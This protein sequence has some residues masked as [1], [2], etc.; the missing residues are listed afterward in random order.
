MYLNGAIVTLSVDKEH[1]DGSD[2]LSLKTGTCG[3]VVQQRH[4]D[5]TYGNHEYIVDFGPYGQWHC[6]HDELSGNESAMGDHEDEEIRIERS[7][8]SSDS[9]GPGTSSSPSGSTR[10]GDEPLIFIDEAA[11]AGLVDLDADIAKRAAEIEKG[12]Y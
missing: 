8:E 2:N 3:M 7:S 9:Y 1:F 10:Q 11:P 4:K 5:T 12:I 6:K